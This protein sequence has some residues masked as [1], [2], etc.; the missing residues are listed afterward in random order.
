MAPKNPL[1]VIVNTHTCNPYN[2]FDQMYCSNPK[3]ERN[4]DHIARR[5]AALKQ[6]LETIPAQAIRLV[7]W[8]AK[9][10]AM[11]TPKFTNPLRPGRP[12]GYRSKPNL[13]VDYILK[14]CH[15]LVWD[16]QFKNST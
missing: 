7:R 5:L 3:V 15:G 4:T 8:Q 11:K 2:P 16:V 1:V 12:P 13:E 14:E 10:V 9:R 6:A